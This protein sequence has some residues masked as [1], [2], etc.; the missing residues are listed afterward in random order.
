MNSNVKRNVVQVRLSDKELSLLN[1]VREMMHCDNNSETLREMI[2]DEN[3]VAVAT[4][5][6]ASGHP[7]VAL[8]L[9]KIANRNHRDPLVYALMGLNSDEGIKSLRAAKAR[10]DDVDNQLS[11]LDWIATNLANSANQVAHGVNS[12]IA[13]DPENGEAWNWV[14]DNLRKLDEVAAEVKQTAREIRQAHFKK[15]LGKYEHSNINSVSE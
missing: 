11:G 15:G 9:K 4:K 12:I 13:T 1:S 10:I 8:E 7:E 3:M 14:F 6:M 2:T 5:M